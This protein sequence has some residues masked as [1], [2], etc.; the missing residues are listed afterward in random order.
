MTV[1]G[2]TASTRRGHIAAVRN[3]TAFLGRS[4]DQA[5][6]EDL[7]RFQ[8]HMEHSAGAFFSCR[9]PIRNL[10]KR[11][12][13]ESGKIFEGGCVHVV[14]G[15]IVVVFILSLIIATHVRR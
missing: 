2:F 5:T 12:A 3:F 8:V 11:L 9:P 1:R 6:A 14:G 7:R 13:S 10:V 4:P 15:A